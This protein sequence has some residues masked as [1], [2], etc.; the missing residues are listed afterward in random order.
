MWQ[1]LALAA[2][3]SCFFALTL[4]LLHSRAFSSAP[5]R[6][7]RASVA[8]VHFAHKHDV[9][10]A[11]EEGRPTR[12]LPS[13]TAKTQDATVNLRSRRYKNRMRSAKKQKAG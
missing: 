13:E 5:V 2:F 11:G 10:Q 3:G 7:R 6:P 12:L 9:A 4:L 8:R 1:S